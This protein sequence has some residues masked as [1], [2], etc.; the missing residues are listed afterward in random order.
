MKGE[1]VLSNKDI[2]AAI[3]KFMLLWEVLTSIAR[4]MQSPHVGRGSCFG[5]D[6]TGTNSWDVGLA[7]SGHRTKGIY[8]LCVSPG[9]L[10]GYCY[11][12]AVHLLCQVGGCIIELFV[13][14]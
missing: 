4:D 11:C 5:F 10:Y 13:R 7:L 3:H 14:I 1:L 6:N 8:D 2:T 9:T 12:F